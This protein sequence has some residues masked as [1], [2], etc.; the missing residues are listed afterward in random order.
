MK[1]PYYFLASLLGLFIISSCQ[2]TKAIHDDV[3][4]AP[5][6]VYTDTKTESGYDTY[7]KNA[8][9]D[10]NQI[11]IEERT[12][13]QDANQSFSNNDNVVI[14]NY[15]GNSVSTGVS[16]GFCD[17]HF[18][19]NC[20]YSHYHYYRPYRNYAYWGNPYI[21]WNYPYYGGWN[22]PYYG[23]YAFGWN[24]YYGGWGSPYYGGYGWGNPYYG[25]YGWGNPYYGGGWGNPYYG[26]WN[27]PYYDGYNNL[28]AGKPSYN[29]GHRSGM[30]TGSRSNNNTAY[31]STVRSLD[32]STGN[33][34]R[35]NPESAVIAKRTEN[36][37]TTKRPAFD[38][39]SG[40]DER[41]VKDFSS[42]RQNNNAT[43]K[44]NTGTDPN[45]P[46]LNNNPEGSRTIR[47]TGQNS[48]EPISRPSVVKPAESRWEA[49]PSRTTRPTTGTTPNTSAPAKTT[50]QPTR[51]E[52][53]RPESPVRTEPTNP[54]NQRT[55]PTNTSPTR[56]EPVRTTPTRTTPTNTAP[57]SR[58]TPTR[59]TPTRTTPTRTAPTRTAPTRTA[60]TRTAPSRSTP[61]RSTTPSRSSGGSSKSGTSSGSGSSRS[62]SGRR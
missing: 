29:Y 53:S 7:I 45:S 34:S 56:T 20:Y 15:Y 2:T 4:D 50:N 31:P 52:T 36:T 25:G 54:N 40:Q 61:S 16:V 19:H 60:P 5:N 59:T 41:I 13:Q 38:Q 55:T 49:S 26:G 21:G 9:N 58:T 3:Y 30:S 57:S 42:S 28:S 24:S 47:P 43:R 27:S 62:G 6:L 11:I 51:T 14:N 48:N 10:D 22:S 35:V 44:P 1:K 33:S 18:R 23:G 37:S 17:V 8:E 46:V 32:A 12:E 39:A